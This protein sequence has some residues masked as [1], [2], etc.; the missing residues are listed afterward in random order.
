MMCPTAPM[1]ALRRACHRIDMPI[2]TVHDL[3]RTFGTRC[4]RQGMY[5][6]HLQDI[7]GHRDITITM[8]Y[9]VHLESLDL[10]DALLKVSI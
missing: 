9:Y 8:R 5:P 3:R 6:K 4:A 10:L 2:V 1:E 7:M